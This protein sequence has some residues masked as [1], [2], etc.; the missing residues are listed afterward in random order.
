MNED[1]MEMYLDGSNGGCYLESLIKCR[2]NLVENTK[3]LKKLDIL[4]E[5]EMELAL[6]GTE[7]AKSEILKKQCKDNIVRPI[8]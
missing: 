6:L 8:K 5:A 1:T 2:I 7:K 4:I 3:L